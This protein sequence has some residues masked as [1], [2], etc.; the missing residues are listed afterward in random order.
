MLVTASDGQAW[1]QSIP[2]SGVLRLGGVIGQAASSD[3]IQAIMLAMAGDAQWR[4]LRLND[5]TLLSNV[6]ARLVEAACRLG[7]AHGTPLR[8]VYRPDSI[9]QH[10]LEAHGLVPAST[11]AAPA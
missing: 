11:T 10:I 1:F 2:D 6:G 3:F 5:V 9:V 8:L 4:E 7:E